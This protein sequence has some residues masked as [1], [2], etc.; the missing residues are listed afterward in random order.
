MTS[1]ELE[2]IIAQ[3]EKKVEYLRKID[4]LEDSIGVYHG[5]LEPKRIASICKGDGLEFFQN[6]VF[7]TRIEDELVDIVFDAM[8][9]YY[10]QKT[11]E[12]IA[13]LNNTKVI[14]P[15]KKGDKK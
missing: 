2:L 12:V 11:D 3:N 1:T 4:A 14:M 6:G 13:W 5:T 9:Q 10:Q 7:L 8:K 15:I